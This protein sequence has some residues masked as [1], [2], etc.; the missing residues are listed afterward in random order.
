MHS[1]VAST[2]RAQIEDA[3]DDGE[4]DEELDLDDLDESEI[5]NR[6][7][8]MMPVSHEAVMTEH[9]KARHRD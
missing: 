5:S 7:A 1:K 2:S 8:H 9:S 4:E 3:A 6:I